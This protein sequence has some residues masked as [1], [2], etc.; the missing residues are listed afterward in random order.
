MLT[1]KKKIALKKKKKFKSYFSPFLYLKKLKIKKKR[2]EKI[3]K[4]IVNLEI[5]ENEDFTCRCYRTKQY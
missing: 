2:G 5:K 4:K 1:L 3:K